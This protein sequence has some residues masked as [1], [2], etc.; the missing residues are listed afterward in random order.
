MPP[1][2]ATVIS[3]AGLAII[4][5]SDTTATVL[6][7][8]VYCLLAHPDTYARLRAEVDAF[9]PPETNALDPAHLP[10]MHYLDAVMCV[11]P[12]LLRALAG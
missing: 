12:L 8:L 7:N 9:Y 4:A 11:L 10:Q 6:A 5:G 3:D 1:A 2:K